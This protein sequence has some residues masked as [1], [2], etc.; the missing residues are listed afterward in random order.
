MGMAVFLLS[1]ES[2][3][4][5]GLDF[6]TTFAELCNKVELAFDMQ[7]SNVFAKLILGTRPLNPWG[8]QLN[9]PI[10][11]LG[12]KPDMRLTVV[13]HSLENCT[14]VPQPGCFKYSNICETTSER[15]FSAQ[16]RLLSNGAA[17]LSA[18]DTGDSQSLARHEGL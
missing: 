11:D 14:E 1:G 15:R 5:N 13:S 7:C 6:S 17:R 8:V 4:V 3:M 9:V 2:K 16:L 18:T 12:L 10:G